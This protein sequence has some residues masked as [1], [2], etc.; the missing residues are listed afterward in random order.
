MDFGRFG[1]DSDSD[2]FESLDEELVARTVRDIDDRSGS[3]QEVL[4]S[5][6]LCA[7]WPAPT[8]Q[9]Q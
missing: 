3:D 4:L 6:L 5:A 9:M 7:A 2:Q 8:S 1:E